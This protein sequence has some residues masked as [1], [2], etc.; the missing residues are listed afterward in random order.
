MTRLSDA[1]RTGTAQAHRRAESSAFMQALMAGTVGLPGYVALLQVLHPIYVALESALSDPHVRLAL[2]PLWRADAPGSSD[3]RQ[4][5]LA[6][7]ARADAI[8]HDL[9]LLDAPGVPTGL[10]PAPALM[11]AQAYAGHV[12]SLTGQPHRLSAHVYLRY[13]G[14]LYGGQLMSRALGPALSAKAHPAATRFLDFGSP[15]HVSQA[16]ATLRAALDALPLNAE[17]QQAVVQE[18]CAGFERHEAVFQSLSPSILSAT[19]GADSA[20]GRGAGLP[21]R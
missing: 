1:L 2:A 13:L 10:S 3:A 6:Y 8:R 16:V 5:L 4:P 7:L 15:Q 19:D 11:L 12:L 21:K 14:D 9:Q 20:A 18:A 17:Q